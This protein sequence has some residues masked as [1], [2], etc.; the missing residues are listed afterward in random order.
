MKSEPII[1]E[2]DEYADVFHATT[3]IVPSFKMR[4]EFLFCMRTTIE[5]VSYTK[6]I[7]PAEK[8]ITNIHIY[9][10]IDKIKS[11][12]KKKQA[13]MISKEASDDKN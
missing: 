10:V 4:L 9:T 13:G 5:S 6:E 7:M 12:F 3:K 8:T 11:L 1:F 2:G